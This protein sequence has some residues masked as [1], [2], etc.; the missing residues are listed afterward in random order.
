MYQELQSRF[1]W[2]Y[3]EGI[4]HCMVLPCK[5]ASGYSKHSV[6]VMHHNPVEKIQSLHQPQPMSLPDSSSLSV[7]Q[8]MPNLRYPQPRSSVD[9]GIGDAQQNLCMAGPD[10][11]FGVRL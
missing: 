9:M 1:R 7:A 11:G 10:I 8:A 5:S 6:M 2:N 3:G 4:A